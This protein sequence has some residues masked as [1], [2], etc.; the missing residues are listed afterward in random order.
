MK[1]H[2]QKPVVVFAVWEPILPT[3]WSKPRTGVLA[4]LSDRRVRQFWDPNHLVAI[5]LKKAEGAGTLH[6]ACCEKSGFLWDLAAVYAPGAQW[7]ELL[8]QP[9]FFDG[10]VFRKTQE[11]NSVIE[12]AQ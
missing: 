8:P 2:A 1:R 6:P 3:D 5:A 10:A 12:K 9:I 7:R 4:R 11:L